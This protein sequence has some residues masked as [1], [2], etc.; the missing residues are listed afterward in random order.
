[1]R[2]SINQSKHNLYE[3]KRPGFTIYKLAGDR[4][5]ALRRISQYN[6]KSKHCFTLEEAYAFLKRNEEAIIPDI[7]E[8]SVHLEHYG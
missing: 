2:L 8:K 5:Q 7:I 1:M 4:Y 6:T 3:P